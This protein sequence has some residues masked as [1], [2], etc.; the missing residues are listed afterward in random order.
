MALSRKQIVGE[1]NDAFARNDVEAFLAHCAD[2]ITWT[3]VGGEAV[4]GRDAI[5]K[6]M[7]QGPSE[8]PMFTVDAVI[9]EGD[10]VVATGNMT[11]PEQ[12]QAVPYSYCDVWRF[13]GNQVVELRAYI[14]RNKSAS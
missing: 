8:P 10:F 3:M 4:Q 5:R 1:I 6:W 14:V 11:M 12:G 2:D 7:C 9:A 13:R